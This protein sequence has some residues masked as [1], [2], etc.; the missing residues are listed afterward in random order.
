MDELTQE[1]EN[2]A[3]KLLILQIDPALAV[4]NELESIGQ[5]LDDIANK[6]IPPFPEFPLPL[7]FPN[8]PEPLKEVSIN[9]F[10]DVSFVE[11]LNFDSSETNSL[12]QKILDKKE[13]PLD[14]QVTLN[15]I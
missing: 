6:E 4:Y 7:P 3:K 13:E 8:I 14:I 15:L 12:L 10:P 9:N 1:Q 2:E 5:K 11:V